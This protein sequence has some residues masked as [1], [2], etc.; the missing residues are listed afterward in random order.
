MS[1]T[2]RGD[3]RRQLVR[4]VINMLR[5]KIL[6]PRS[7]FR[8]GGRPR[9]RPRHRLSSEA[10]AAHA[11]TSECRGWGGA[12]LTKP[13]FCC[14]V[15]SFGPDPALPLPTIAKTRLGLAAAR[16]GAAFAAGDLCLTMCLL[17]PSWLSLPRQSS[18][19][20]RASPLAPSFRGTSANQRQI[21]ARKKTNF[22]IWFRYF[23]NF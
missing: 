13:P 3:V 19:F 18:R 4:R 1:R 14:E 8:T 15:S 16:A 7:A 2:P 6:T 9:L 20:S 11:S 23:S 5:Q 10:T 21:Q 17:T 22:A 12:T